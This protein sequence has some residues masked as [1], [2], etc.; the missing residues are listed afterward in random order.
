LPVEVRQAATAEREA[1]EKERRASLAA[2][3]GRQAAAMRELDKAHEALLAAEVRRD[4][5]AAELAAA[6]LACDAARRQ[7]EEAEERARVAGLQ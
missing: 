4:A 1:R 6:R 2:A 3:E 5:L 7:L